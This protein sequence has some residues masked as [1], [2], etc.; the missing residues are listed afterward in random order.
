MKRLTV[1]SS[2][3]D[4]T[5]RFTCRRQVKRVVKTILS[6]ASMSRWSGPLTI[7]IDEGLR[8]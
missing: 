1:K 4:I 7:S 8:N 2:V 3:F 5:T 6:S